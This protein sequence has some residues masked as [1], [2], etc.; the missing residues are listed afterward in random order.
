MQTIL[1]LRLVCRLHNLNLN[2]TSAQST[3]VLFKLD[4]NLGSFRQVLCHSRHGCY[5]QNHILLICR[6]QP[7]Q[8]RDT[9]YVDLG[10]HLKWIILFISFNELYNNSTSSAA[11]HS[12][13]SII[14]N[15]SCKTRTKYFPHKL[16]MKIPE[17]PAMCSKIKKY[18]EKYLYF[19]KVRILNK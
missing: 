16:F 13:I 6:S 15:I 5:V 9:A 17:N 18:W 7:N 4:I 12:L 10:L 1:Q 11:I 19:S 2:Y 3:S 14:K 8:G